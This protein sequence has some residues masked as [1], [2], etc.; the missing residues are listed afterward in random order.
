MAPPKPNQPKPGA[1]GGS[2]LKRLKDN[3]KKAGV[4][5]V[6][7]SKK[8]AK[9]TTPARKSSLAQ[10]ADEVLKSIRS[11][12]PFEQKVNR[13]KHDVLGRKLKGSRGQPG[14]TRQKGLETR[15]DALLKDI[16][17]RHKVGS[18][19]D[20]RIGENNPNLSAEEKMMLRWTK[21]KQKSASRKKSH[22]SI[23]DDDTHGGSLGGLTHLG[24]S[25]DELANF[26]DFGPSD[27]EYEGALSKEFVNQALFGGGDA[28]KHKTKADIM[29]ELIAKAKFHKAERQ[30]IKEEN[31]EMRVELDEELDAIR[32]L[33]LDKKINPPPSSSAAAAAAAGNDD[34]AF[35][36]IVRELKF[37]KRAK[38]T[39]RT[40]TEEEIAAE[41]KERLERLE[42]QRL[43][44]M[45]GD[46]DDDSDDER[47]GGF[48][49]RRLKRKKEEE[50]AAAA[51]ARDGSDSD[52]SLGS[53][54]EGGDDEMPLTY[55]D[56]VL[57]NKSVFVKSR[58]RPAAS[59]S[60]EEEGESEDEGDEEDQ[61]DGSDAEGDDSDE[62]DDGSDLASDDEEVG[63]EH[64]FSASEDEDDQPKSGKLHLTEEERTAMMAQAQAEL[65]YTFL[66]PASQAEFDLFVRGRS[67]SDIKTLMERFRALYHPSLGEGNK[68]RQGKVLS[69]LLCHLFSQDGSAAT[70]HS[71]FDTLYPVV[72]DMIKAHTLPAAQW[73]SDTL[74]ALMSAPGG[75]FRP[76]Q[77][78]M[79]KLLLRVFSASDFHH[80]VITPLLV[81]LAHYLATHPPRSVADATVGLFVVALC[82]DVQEQSKRWLP[83]AFNYTTA[84]VAAYSTAPVDANLFPTTTAE[85]LPTASANLGAAPSR[86]P[87]DGVTGG[88]AKRAAAH[89]SLLLT[90]LRTL[91]RFDTLYH[92]ALPSVPE[93]YAPVLDTLRALPEAKMHAD[94]L[95]QCDAVASSMQEHAD[96]AAKTR[97][98]LQLQKHRPVAIAAKEPEYEAHYSLDRRDNPDHID[99]EA[100]KLKAQ[101]KKEKKGAIRELRRDA[102]FL[103]AARV[104][105]QK[106]KDRE[107]EAKMKR[108]MGRLG[109]EVGELNKAERASKRLKKF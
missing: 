63:Q 57:I 86:L 69:F 16:A 107:Y 40:K 104:Q 87:L 101:Y 21:E 27:D 67:A 68:D 81:V 77:L 11:K 89:A 34:D 75:T 54:D 35:D 52:G 90:A 39:D 70:A 10:R 103:A 65:P 85:S 73:A 95:T 56:G 18:F 42:R 83:E 59:D 1:S 12:N 2:T 106:R 20:R 60:E 38:P 79:F 26:D 33:L 66:A 32:G 29:K 4:I 72:V 51:G 6:K 50:R 19:V 5:G 8:I 43:R 53:D 7:T 30:R 94:L 46:S 14:L 25:I 23:D 93:L 48:R 91:A 28:N 17:S 80:A 24:Q 92:A 96:R 58:N 3:L 13:T 84:L 22:F 61:E 15:K 55:R 49:Q 41:E 44:R 9:S 45:N 100:E 88:K 31:E 62:D 78:L 64:E 98:V 76:A 99:K 97:S 109:D 71:T 47:G 74:S 36:Q 82:L 102:E 105:E 37:D 108:V